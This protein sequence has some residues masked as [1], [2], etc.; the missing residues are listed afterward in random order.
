MNR[1]QELIILFICIGIGVYG[2]LQILMGNNITPN[3]GAMGL[4]AGVLT[5]FILSRY[6]RGIITKKTGVKIE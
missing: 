5:V 2:G 6:Q 3:Y 4:G 1:N